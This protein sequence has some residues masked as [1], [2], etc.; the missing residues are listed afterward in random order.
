M[1]LDPV[2]AELQRLDVGI[3]QLFLALELLA[4]QPLDL[5]RVDVEQHRQRADI[6]DVLEQLALAGI[7]VGGVGDG[8]QR[9]ADHVDVVAEHRRRHRLGGVVEQVA[10]RL[11]LLDVLAQVCGFIATIMSTPPRRPR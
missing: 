7:G 1:L 8:G 9:H 2:A 3:D 6:D 5:R 11:D 4:E 10:A